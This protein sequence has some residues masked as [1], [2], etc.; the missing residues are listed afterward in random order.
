MTPADLWNLNTG[1]ICDDSGMNAP[2]RKER[3][4]EVHGAPHSVYGR[5][6]SNGR[7]GHLG[8]RQMPCLPPTVETKLRLVW[9]FEVGQGH[10]QVSLPEISRSPNR[11]L[12]DG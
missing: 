7:L 8:N 12:G 1:M 2:P 3:V 11:K 4:D 9:P 10:Y 6:M 5:P